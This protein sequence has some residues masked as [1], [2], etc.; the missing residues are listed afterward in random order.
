MTEST[1]KLTPMGLRAENRCFGCGPANSRGL[2][3]KFLTAED[4]SVVCLATIPVSFEGPSGYT[5]GGIIATMLDE[6]MS[7]SLRARGL[8]AVTRRMEI[9]LLRPVSLGAPIRLEGRLLGGVGRKHQTEA[10]ILDARGRV[11]A[12]AKG[13]FVELRS[14]HSL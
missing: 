14:G 13:L 9:E 2:Q 12:T 3:L 10:R 11:L 1:E 8:T 6:A 7:K 4:L 5:H